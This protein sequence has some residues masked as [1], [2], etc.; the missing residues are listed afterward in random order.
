MT[1]NVNSFIRSRKKIVAITSDRITHILWYISECY[2]ILSKDKPQYSKSYVSNDTTFHFEDYLKMELVDK[3][4]IPNKHL[5]S[6]KLSKL[7]NINFHY[8]NQKRYVDTRDKKEKVD[9]IDIYIN[10]LGLQ[11]NWKEK[12]ENIYFVVE[13]KRILKLSDCKKY[14][15]DIKN[16]AD[17][18]YIN[19]RLPFEGQIGFIENT[20]ITHDNLSKAIS[21][22]L[23]NMP[24]TINTKAYLYN[25]KI[26]KVFTGCYLSKHIRNHTDKDE[27]F[28]YHLLFDY[29][30]F[31]IS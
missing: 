31:V 1:D 16:F 19:L 23:K 17:R 2:T 8:E 20:K 22:E 7:E 6:S 26:H 10:R 30:P 14:I 5:I 11:N 9:K 25:I 24:G 13:C 29:S 3:Y 15:V 27:F 28:V 18:K 4:L 21:K 12:E